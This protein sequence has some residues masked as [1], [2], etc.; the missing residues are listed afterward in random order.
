[1]DSTLV[2]RIKFALGSRKSQKMV[3]EFVKTFFSVREF[4]K[5]KNYV[6]EFVNR[7]LPGGASFFQMPRPRLR[8]HEEPM[9]CSQ[10][11]KRPQ[12]HKIKT[13]KD[14]YFMQ[15]RPKETTIETK[16]DQTAE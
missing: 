4:V 3:R 7:P 8:L 9:Q 11:I 15:K 1:M 2:M 16:K 14:H 10:L 13:K 6:R 12:N 5:M